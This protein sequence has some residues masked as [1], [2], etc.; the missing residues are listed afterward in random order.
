MTDATPR[1][2]PWSSPDGKPSYVLGDGT[3]MVSRLADDIEEAQLFLA[4]GLV[5]DA[6]RLL[7]A[8]NW[9]TG[10]LHLLTVELAE[11]LVEIRRI[12]ASRG[13]RLRAASPVDRPT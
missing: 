8:R 7:G 11:S 13:A 1:L 10:E 9:T 4:D 3:G 6:R 5:E 12:A 2:L